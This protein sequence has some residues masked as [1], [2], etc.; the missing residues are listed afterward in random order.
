MCVYVCGC[1]GGKIFLKNSQ[2]E[3]VII[4]MDVFMCIF[5]LGIEIASSQKLFCFVGFN[6]YNV[7]S[8]DFWTHF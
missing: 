7:D 5:F 3:Y 2:G 6:L 4:Y 1:W 8:I